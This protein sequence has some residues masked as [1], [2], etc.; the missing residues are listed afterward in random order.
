MAATATRRR[1]DLDP[2]PPPS[3]LSAPI[4]VT[5]MVKTVVVRSGTASL[6]MLAFC[7]PV[8]RLRMT[9]SA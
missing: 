3:A 8:A 5:V 6:R 4:P 7:T 2:F 1:P 9:I